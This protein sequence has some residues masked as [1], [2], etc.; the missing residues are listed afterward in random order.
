MLNLN[1]PEDLAEFI[2]SLDTKLEMSEAFRIN[3]NKRDEDFKEQVRAKS[4]EIL[5]SRQKPSEA[6]F[7]GADY[8]P[9]LDDDRLNKQIGRVYEAMKDGQWR[10]LAELEA[11]TKDPQASISAQIRHL[12]KARFGSYKTERERC[13][14]SGTWRY[15]LNTEQTKEQEVEV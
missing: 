15:R 2:M 10:T 11:I 9:A 3:T 5:E 14:E 12:R 4:R 6:R 8:N 7:N 13:G 1:D